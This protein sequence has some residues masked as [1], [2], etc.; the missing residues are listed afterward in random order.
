MM[1][2]I[3]VLALSISAVFTVFAGGEF[4]AGFSR[5]DITPPTGGSIPGYFRKRIADGVLDPLVVE[6]V[7]FSWKGETGLVFAVDNIHVGE[8][9]RLKANAVIERE[10]GIPAPRQFI[11][12]TH[13]HTGGETQVRTHHTPEEAAKARAYA[14]QLV[15]GIVASAKAACADLAPSS[16]AVGSTQCRGVSFIRRF[17]MKDGSART[18]PKSGDKNIVEPLGEPDESLQLLRIKRTGA[19]D[20]AIINFGT[21]PDTV[22]G[23]RISADWP[24][25][26]RSTFEN[27]IGGGVK[28]LM[29]NGAQGDVNH[30]DR[31]PAAGRKKL[32]KVKV[33]E[34]MGRRIAGAAM[35]IWDICEDVEA[36]PVKGGI[37]RMKVPVK[38]PSEDEKK[39]IALFDAGRKD[40]IP[41]GRMEILTLTKPYSFARRFKNGPK[42][43]EM[44]VSALSVGKSIAFAG[45]P[46]EPF[47]KIA[48]DVKAASPFRMTMAA[49]LV[50]GSRGYLPSTDAFAQGGY[51]V[52]S[53]RFDKSVGDRLVETQLKQLNRLYGESDAAPAAADAEVGSLM[54]NNR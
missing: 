35:G 6:C 29:L 47:V 3:K 12:S 7:A 26:V 11:N 38:M 20:I 42:F 13:T 2:K 23:T 49:C 48:L 16:L 32:P 8:K 44:P 4:K 39:W 50:N 18:N 28:C 37:D 27:G 17:R 24:A 25:F 1:N 31:N 54:K 19:P 52:L 40:E 33:R 5:V 36:G 9:L 41:L 15:A 21:H 53:S 45:F 10:L 46:G 14:K 51:E 43:I 22:G 34:Y 30:R